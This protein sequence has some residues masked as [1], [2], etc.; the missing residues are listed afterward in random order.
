[1]AQWWA[2]VRAHH[3]VLIYTHFKLHVCVWY[4]VACHEKSYWNYVKMCP[5]NLLGWICRH[6]AEDLH[7]NRW[8]RRTQEKPADPDL[9]EKNDHKNGSSTVVGGDFVTLTCCLRRDCF[10]MQCVW[11]AVRQYMWLFSW[12]SENICTPSFVQVMQRC[13]LAH[14]SW[15]T[16]SSPARF[17]TRPNPPITWKILTRIDPT[18]SQ[19]A[20]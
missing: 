6:P 20:K 16:P 17:V 5:G 7:W 3:H 12:P 1:M 15:P 13:P 2:L 4:C 19:C 11:N 18:N 10:Q 9:L 8:R 14:F